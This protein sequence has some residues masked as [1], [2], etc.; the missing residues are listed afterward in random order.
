MKGHSALPDRG[1]LERMRQ[2]IGRLVEEHVAQAPAQDYPHG[3]V[4]QEVFEVAAVHAGERGVRATRQP[5]AAQQEKAQESHEVH[6]A[7]PAH[8]N[9]AQLQG[10][11]VKLRMDE[12]GG[13]G[14]VSVECSAV[15]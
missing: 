5:Q 14:R 4:E 8:G 11:R 3:A 15:F 9:R 6:Q 7:I 13:A 12:H 10:D 1:N 2:V